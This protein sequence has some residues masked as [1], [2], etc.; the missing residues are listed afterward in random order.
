MSSRVWVSCPVRI[1]VHVWFVSGF[2][3]EFVSGSCPVRARFVSVSCPVR[4]WVH[5]LFA[6][7]S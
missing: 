2:V 7:V 6:F 4:V 1:W 3:F 5:I